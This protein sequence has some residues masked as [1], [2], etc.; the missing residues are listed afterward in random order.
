MDNKKF[1]AVI[2]LLKEVLEKNELTITCQEY[3]IMQL[4]DQIKELNSKINRKEAHDE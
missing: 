1:L 4:K 3:E 2:E